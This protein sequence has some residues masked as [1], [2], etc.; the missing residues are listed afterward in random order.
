MFKINSHCTFYST[1]MQ[2]F[3]LSKM[4]FSLLCKSNSYHMYVTTK[5]DFVSVLCPSP[6]WCSDCYTYCHK[7]GTPPWSH[8]HWW[9][10]PCMGS[11]ELRFYLQCHPTTFTFSLTPMTCAACIE[12][13]PSPMMT[14]I[15]LTLPFLPLKDNLPHNT[16]TCQIYVKKSIRFH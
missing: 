5:R 15:N 13:F 12:T 14:D 8:N 1:C 11:W 10:A 16:C 7:R 6:F 4:L 2:S 9:V 3:V